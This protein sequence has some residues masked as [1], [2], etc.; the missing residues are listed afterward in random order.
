M[1]SLQ[2]RKSSVMCFLLLLHHDRYI[3][4]WWLCISAYKL[5]FKHWCSFRVYVRNSHS[6]FPGVICSRSTQFNLKTNTESYYYSF[7]YTFF[8]S[9]WLC[10]KWLYCLL[11]LAC[12]PRLC[13]TVTYTRNIFFFL[14]HSFY[15]CLSSFCR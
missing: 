12:T 15:A 6:C 10:S 4:L 9:L 1:E 2:A 14:L 13:D 11:G 3:L 5:S 8:W 7:S